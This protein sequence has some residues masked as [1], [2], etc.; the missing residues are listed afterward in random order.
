MEKESLLIELLSLERRIKILL[1]EF[2]SA[3]NEAEGLKNE[4]QRLK[5]LLEEKEHHV[6]SFQSQ[7][8][9]STIGKYLVTSESEPTKLKVKIDEYIAEIDRCIDH[10]KK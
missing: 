8:N 9:M 4:N 3:K 2:K 7:I 10:L 5:I 1:L 6:E